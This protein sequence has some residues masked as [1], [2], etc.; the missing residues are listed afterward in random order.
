MFYCQL[1]WKLSHVPFSNQLLFTECAV[2][3]TSQSG[4]PCQ[5][6]AMRTYGKT[7]LDQCEC[8]VEKYVNRLKDWCI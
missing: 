5:Q 3:Y 6:C 7:Y 8:K 1:R 4:Y 2:G